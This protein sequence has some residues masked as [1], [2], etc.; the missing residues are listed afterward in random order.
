MDVDIDVDVSDIGSVAAVTGSKMT[1][2]CAQFV[3]APWSANK[4]AINLHHWPV[5]PPVAHQP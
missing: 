1:R 4:L 5:D 3:G 2:V